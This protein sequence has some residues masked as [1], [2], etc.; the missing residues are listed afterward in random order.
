MNNIVENPT[1]SFIFVR[2]L[3]L[4]LWQCK[5]F[6]YSINILDNSSK[7]PQTSM[8]LL[9]FWHNCRTTPKHFLSCSLELKT[10]YSKILVEKV[11]RFSIMGLIK[12][13]W[14]TYKMRH[15]CYSFDTLKL[16]LKHSWKTLGKPFQ[17]PLKH[18]CHKFVLHGKH[19]WTISMGCAGPSTN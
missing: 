17:I 3:L 7:K 19:S 9:W 12:K 2:S 1:I 14:K 8:K 10:L 13:N 6:R 18:P 11:V 4:F 5:P 15:L 16:S